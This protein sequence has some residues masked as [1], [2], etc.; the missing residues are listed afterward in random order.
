MKNVK[1]I[2]VF[3]LSFLVAAAVVFFWGFCRFFVFP[4]GVLPSVKNI[5]IWHGWAIGLPFAVSRGWDILLAFIGPPAIISLFFNE[6]GEFQPGDDLYLMVI[7]LAFAVAIG[8]VGI[9]LS[10]AI[11]LLF[12]IIARG[13]PAP[14]TTTINV[15]LKFS[16]ILGFVLGLVYGI[17][18]GF[19]IFSV[20]IAPIIPVA[21][22]S[23]IKKIILKHDLAT[24][25]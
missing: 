23:L 21:I 14:G 13:E 3:E 12:L 19:I 25:S 17:I 6:K 11:G 8:F 9:G 20:M 15:I 18:S 16:V 10:T 22:S 1:S 4:E 5:T 24:T 2:L 7:A